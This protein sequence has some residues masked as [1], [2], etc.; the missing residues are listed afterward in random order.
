[1]VTRLLEGIEVNPRYADASGFIA[2]L[3]V[4]SGLVRGIAFDFEGTPVGTVTDNNDDAPWPLISALSITLPL[5]RGDVVMQSTGRDLY[6]LSRYLIG[7]RREDAVAASNAL[8]HSMFQLLFGPDGWGI[9]SLALRT[10]A[11][12]VIQGTWAAATQYGAGCTG[13]TAG[14]LRPHLILEAG[15]P[16]NPGRRAL[17]P[18][19]TPLLVE[20]AARVP[21]ARINKPEMAEGLFGILYRQEDTSIA[22]DRV[23]GLVTRVAAKHPQLGELHNNFFRHLRGYGVE[24]AGIDPAEVVAATP[25]GLDGTA[26]YVAAPTFKRFPGIARHDISIMHDSAETVPGGTSDVTPAAGDRLHCTL[27]A[28]ILPGA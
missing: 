23:D 18:T 5:K 26:F 25:R 6:L 16:T 11:E 20:S 28:T 21:I 7:H 15:A 17:I 12:I 24:W 1:M 19:T 8:T 9:H 14:I 3:P 22:A 13:I 10:G 27:V 2:R 4:P